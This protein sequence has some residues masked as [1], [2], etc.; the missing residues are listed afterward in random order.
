MAYD[1]IVSVGAE[2]ADIS[3]QILEQIKKADN[4]KVRI[5]CDDREIKRVLGQLAKIDDVAADKI[6]IDVDGVQA[7]RTLTQI[8]E[9]A[10]K[11]IE[12]ITTSNFEKLFNLKLK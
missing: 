11:E 12:N 10:L 5:K 9:D 8:R 7:T 4:S 2:V 1:Y 3:S 6:L